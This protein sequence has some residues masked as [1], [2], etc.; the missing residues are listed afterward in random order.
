MDVYQ[1]RRLVALSVVAAIF[2]LLV[3]LIRSCGGDDENAS[4]LTSSVPATT[5]VGGATPLSQDDFVSEG[6]TICLET[7]TALGALDSADPAQDASDRANL[8]SGELE[9]RQSLALAP[10]EKGETKLE[11]FLSALSKQ[12]Q[13]YDDLATATDRNDEASITELTTTIDQASADAQHAAERFGFKV[14]GDTSKVSETTGN[15]GEAAGGGTTAPAAPT[16]TT[17]VAPTTTT[18]VAPTTEGGGATPAPG[19]TGGGTGGTGGST[20][21]SGGLTP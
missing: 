8:L 5:G 9:S 1:R 17:P 18:P 7:N 4:P 15:G 12:A 2:V 21:G 13:G 20:S 3:L 6:D 16:E 14:C 11:N 19:T 10:G